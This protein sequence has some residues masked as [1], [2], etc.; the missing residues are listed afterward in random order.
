M[1]YLRT[2]MKTKKIELEIPE[3]FFNTIDVIA[4]R[5]GVSIEDVAVLSLCYACFIFLNKRLVGIV[6]EAI[7]D[8]K[9]NK[10]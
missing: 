7:R 1:K 4:K 5:T 3:L 8:L 10:I 2:T 9:Y 6:S